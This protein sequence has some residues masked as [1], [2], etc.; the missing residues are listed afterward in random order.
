MKRERKMKKERAEKAFVKA[1][2]E[3]HNKI[4]SAGIAYPEV[5]NYKTLQSKAYALSK[6]EDIQKSIICEIERTIPGK[7]AI[8][9]LKNKMEVEGKDSVKALSLYFDLV[10]AKKTEH[11]VKSESKN[12]NFNINIDGMK[13]Q[14]A[15]RKAREQVDK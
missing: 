14:E 12:L 15:V 10:G 5:E 4:Q 3:G 1:R 13:V 7:W 11:L 8:E 6:R 2:A 9:V